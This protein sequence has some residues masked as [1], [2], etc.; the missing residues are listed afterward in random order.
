MKV[1]MIRARMNFYPRSPCGE[2]PLI[3]AYNIIVGKISIHALLA[4][5]DTSRTLESSYNSYFYPRSPCGERQE[6]QP[7]CAR[8]TKD[9]YPRSPCG[10]RLF[11]PFQRPAHPH[12]Y[13]RSPCG[14]RLAILQQATLQNSNFYPR[15]PCGER[16]IWGRA[17]T[18]NPVIS[19]HAL[20]AESDPEKSESLTT[21]LISIH[22]LLAES[23]RTILLDYQR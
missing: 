21:Y 18:V 10:E 8:P 4:E 11:Q 3:M 14:E 12:F 5:S 13:P 22:A 9:F 15:S 16:P 2:R 17:F 20:L 6:S 23:D 1:R 19:I 7:P